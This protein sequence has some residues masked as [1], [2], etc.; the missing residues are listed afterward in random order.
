MGL[1]SLR[2][3]RMKTQLLRDPPGCLEDCYQSLPGSEG[4]HPG[5]QLEIPVASFGT[6]VF[7]P[8]PLA[9]P[10]YLLLVF[11][12]LL[13]VTL[14][15]ET[16]AHLASVVLSLAVWFLCGGR[17]VLYPHPPLHPIPDLA[18]PRLPSIY[19]PPSAPTGANRGWD[20]KPALLWGHQAGLLEASA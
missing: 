2:G 7:L 20:S 11:L 1:L 19:A 9:P 18:P 15:Y 16:M 6:T 4:R 14:F 17:P 8:Y 10:S 12:F 13:F 5:Y 3:C